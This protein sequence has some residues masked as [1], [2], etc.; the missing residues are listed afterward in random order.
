MAPNIINLCRIL[1]T[2]WQLAWQPGNTLVVDESVYEYLGASP[3]HVYI[4]RKPHPNG[5]MSYGISGYTSVL[6]LPMLLDLEP[7]VPS[8]KLS[9]RDSAKALVERTR[10]AH[11]TLQLHVVMDSAFGSFGDVPLYHSK[12]V[13]VTT[14][15]AENKK[16]WL[17]DLLGYQCPLEAGR[18]AL[19]PMD[20]TDDYFL[21]SLYRTKSDSG[22]TIDIRTVTSA[23]DFTKPENPEDEVVSVGERRE[24]ANGLFEYHTNWTD[25]SA[26]WQ[27]AR[28]FMDDDGTFNFNWLEKAE[29]EDVQAAL[30]DLTADELMEL[31][32][33]QS[34]KV[35]LIIH[36]KSHF[37]LNLCFK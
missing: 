37:R 4:P 20:G 26:T 11:P 7:W 17:W 15:M 28:S 1:G 12:A 16:S 29:N 25:G 9:A 13:S 30:R 10:A 18:T 34:W 33:R 35:H 2:Q 22:K 8:N 14:S 32:D 27:Q 24:N 6:R 21:A 31:C 19:F 36:F 3:C 5:I 23:F